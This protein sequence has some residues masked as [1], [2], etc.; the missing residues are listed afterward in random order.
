MEKIGIL[1]QARM[2]SSRLPGK[3]LKQVAGVP[4]LVK[5]L[6]R[7]SKN[8]LGIKPVVITTQLGEDDI[9]NQTV[10]KF[11]YMCIRGSTEDLLD[12]HYL[13]AETL[14]LQAVC[15][16]PSDC[17]FADPL[18]IDSVIEAF[19]TREKG[20]SY[21]S[22]YHPPTFPDGLDVEIADINAL[23]QAWR[24]ASMKHEREHTFPYIWDNPELFGITNVLNPFGCMFM[25]HRWT[26]DY[27]ED[28][29]FIRRIYEEFDGLIFTMK[30][31]L[32]LLLEKPELA[33]INGRLCG[34]NW[35]RSSQDKLKTISSEYFRNDE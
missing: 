32:D 31:I 20:I 23:E 25:S 21:V 1:V 9:I 26:L 6:E 27:E 16:I 10:E 17:P 15:K 12:R 4:V 11:G 8:S 35:Y 28:L 18:V 14:G 33:R 7:I 5:Q 13:A 19:L 24:G 29:T 3:V 22:N 34:L 30:D 2:G